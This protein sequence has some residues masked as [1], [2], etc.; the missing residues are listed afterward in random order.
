L[1]DSILE[2]YFP[3]LLLGIREPDAALRGP[4]VVVGRSEVTAVVGHPVA[5][6]QELLPVAEIG[7]KRIRF[8]LR[9]EPP[10]FAYGYSMETAQY[11]LPWPGQHAVWAVETLAICFYKDL[12]YYLEH[13]D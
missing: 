8:F 12:V 11:E 9:V 6:S 5:V 10:C 1:L 4:L 3:R 2:N 7:P 13:Q